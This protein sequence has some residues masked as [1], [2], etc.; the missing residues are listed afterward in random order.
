MIDTTAASVEETA[1][2]QLARRRG[3]VLDGWYPAALDGVV[4]YVRDRNF[5]L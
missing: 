2:K 4:S 5:S 1:L 3:V